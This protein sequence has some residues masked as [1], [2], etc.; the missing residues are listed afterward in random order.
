MNKRG[1]IMDMLTIFVILLVAIILVIVFLVFQRKVNDTIQAINQ[2]AG[3]GVN[4]AYAADVSQSMDDNFG[5]VLD[6]IIIMLFISL[7][8]VSMMLA[9]MNYIP[10]FL[11]YAVI[12]ITM[13][14]VALGAGFSLGFTNLINGSSDAAIASS[15]I[16]M[17]SFVFSHFGFYTLFAMILIISGVYVKQ[18]RGP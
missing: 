4:T 12:G 10:P 7:P 9:F 13:L 14:M 2:T 17:T 8:I 5:W 3:P 16:P 15:R 1:N 6:F 18:S 11:F